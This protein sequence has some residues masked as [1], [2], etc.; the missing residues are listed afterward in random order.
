MSFDAV[1][2]QLHGPCSAIFTP[3]DAADE[4]NLD[5]LSRV[6]EFQLASGLRGFFVA[7]STGEGLLMS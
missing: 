1:V 5:M 2:D 4:V 7:G 6:V 3:F